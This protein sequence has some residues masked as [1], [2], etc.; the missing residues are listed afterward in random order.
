ML[1]YNNF[2][3]SVY[4]SLKF[5]KINIL[6]GDIFANKINIL[7]GEMARKKKQ[8]VE[9]KNDE[10]SLLPYVMSFLFA[11]AL[12]LIV[13]SVNP[14]VEKTGFAA[15]TEDVQ[16]YCVRN[17]EQTSNVAVDSKDSCCFLIENTDRCRPANGESAYYRGRSGE[18]E[19]FLD[20]DYACFGGSTDKVFF[21]DEVRYYCGLNI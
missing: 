1:V 13:L 9:I 16:V 6:I 17:S 20:Y 5:R 12:F 4:D 14:N 8:I 18:F 7:S 19:G 21:T 11:G 10:P 15:Q 3:A 2:H